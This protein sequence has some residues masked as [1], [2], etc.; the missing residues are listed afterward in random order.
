[1]E[2]TPVT[3]KDRK[4]A[5]KM[6]RKKRQNV[7]SRQ[8]QQ[9]ID[10]AFAPRRS[11][12]P[13][14][15]QDEDDSYSV[16]TGSRSSARP[17]AVREGGTENDHDELTLQTQ[18]GPDTER[19]FGTSIM[20]IAAVVV[21][22]EVVLPDHEPENNEAMP[23]AQIA[24]TAKICGR[25][26]WL[27]FT[28]LGVLLTGAIV[29]SLVVALGNGD[30]RAEIEK[31]IS[32]EIPSFQLGPFQIEALNWLAYDD[33]ANLDF[34]HD[35]H[36]DEL[37]ERFVMALLYFSMGGENWH[38]SFG[39]LSGFPVCM[40]NE[41]A[42]DMYND[43][44]PGVWCSAWSVA[45]VGLWGNNLQGQL[46]TELFLLSRLEVLDLSKNQIFGLVPT[47][48][49]RLAELKYFNLSKSATISSSK[50]E[51][52]TLFG[53][54]LQIITSMRFRR[55]ESVDRIHPYRVG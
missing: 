35:L 33:P 11:P 10:Q 34:E 16:A 52:K 48:L 40:W 36:P 6:R 49:G 54:I 4:E 13:P 31:K 38:D 25:S 42:D 15:Q 39:F 17:G 20:P 47:E 23:E 50:L 3:P 43:G 24:D 51:T 28:L 44:V 21:L 14:S 12:L 55:Q 5:R 1:M 46:P 53:S 18:E 37:L 26:R 30:R 45:I 27:I 2:N 41:Y 7:S 29:T 22:G 19:G 9:E 8:D 32:T